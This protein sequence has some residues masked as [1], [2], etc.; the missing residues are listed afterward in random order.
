MKK[1]ICLLI[2]VISILSCKKETIVTTK[3]V[4]DISLTPEEEAM[5][6]A[7]N[8]S[9]D[10]VKPDVEAKTTTMSFENAMHDFGVIKQGSK[11]EHNFKFTNTGSND[12]I[13]TNAKG[14]CGCT[15]PEYP[16]EAVKPGEAGEIKVSFNSDGKSGEQTKSVT[17]TANTPKGSEILTI[18]AT[19]VVEK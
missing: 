13:I 17:I 1:I 18:K 8:K 2:V 9:F 11:V 7:N 3:K 12:L 14:S 19:I 16:K 15:I 4:P 10:V 5:I 6:D